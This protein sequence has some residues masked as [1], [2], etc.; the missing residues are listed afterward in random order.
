MGGRRCGVRCEALALLA[1][2]AG[3]VMVAES[4]QAALVICQKGSKIKLR[5]DACKGKETQ[6][7]ATE[8]GVTGPAGTNGMDGTNG[9]N[10]MDGAPGTA[11]AYAHVLQDGTLDA[12]NSKNVTQANVTL[13]STSAYCFSGLTFQ[14]KSAIANPDYGDPTSGG[15]EGLEATV[16]LGDPFGD[17][18]NVTG[19]QLEVATSIGG[20]FA[21]SGFF[22]IFN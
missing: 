3:V 16:A 4:A 21:K 17:C 14:F 1:L 22:V 11:I 6:V 12:A 20:T 13:D 8:L 9:T 19:T 15:Q 18:S 7:P 2:A 5:Q 10:G